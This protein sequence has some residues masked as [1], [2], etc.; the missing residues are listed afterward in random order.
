[1]HKPLKNKDLGMHARLNPGPSESPGHPEPKSK[2]GGRPMWIARRVSHCEA[3]Q[4]AGE[5]SWSTAA[6]GVLAEGPV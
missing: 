6:F 5:P 1:M 2:R 4:Q 3:Y